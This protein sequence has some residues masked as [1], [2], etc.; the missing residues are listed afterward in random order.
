MVLDRGAVGEDRADV[1]GDHRLVVGMVAVHEVVVDIVEVGDDHEVEVA[2]VD[3]AR[4]P[5]S[6]SCGSRGSVPG[7]CNSRSCTAATLRRRSLPASSASSR[8]DGTSA[9]PLEQCGVG[10]AVDGERGAGDVA[11]VLGA[12]ERG[13]VAEVGRDRRSTPAGIPAAGSPPPPC[14]AA[15]RSVACSPGSS[16]LTVTPSAATSRASVFRNPVTPGPRGVR[17]DERRRSAGAPRST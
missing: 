14:S 8:R 13:E 9:A 5:R 2:L 1:L 15:M 3:A 11:G 6:R 16:E 12:Q 7:S 10:A 17:E 4:R